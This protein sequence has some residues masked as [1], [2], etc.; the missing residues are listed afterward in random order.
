MRACGEVISPERIQQVLIAGE[1]LHELQLLLLLCKRIFRKHA[2]HLVKHADFRFFQR[3]IGKGRQRVREITV[4]HY[5]ASG[6]S[7]RQLA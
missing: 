2:A 3:D 5:L 6:H 7:R 1:G 4:D